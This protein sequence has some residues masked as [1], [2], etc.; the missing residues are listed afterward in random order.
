MIPLILTYIMCF[1]DTDDY[2]SSELYSIL[3]K[4]TS[5]ANL[6][7]NLSMVLVI[8]PGIFLTLSMIKIFLSTVEI[9]HAMILA[10]SLVGFTGAAL[11]LSLD[12]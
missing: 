10:L 6:N 2:L 3:F 1:D 5:S 12:N 9:L 8:S 11:V 4:D 7:F